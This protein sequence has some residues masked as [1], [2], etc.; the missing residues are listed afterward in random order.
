MA[1]NRIRPPS[2]YDNSPLGS[3]RGEGG[4]HHAEEGL[5][6]QY[7]KYGHRRLYDG[8]IEYLCQ[9]CLKVGV[10]PSMNVPKCVSEILK[11]P[12]LPSVAWKWLLDSYQSENP[13]LFKDIVFLQAAAFARGRITSMQEIERGRFA[14]ISKKNQAET[15]KRQIAM[16]RAKTRGTPEVFDASQWDRLRYDVLSKSEGRCALCGR[17]YREHGVT[18]EV[19]HIKPKSRFPELSLDIHNL[20]VLCKDCNRGKSNRDTRDWR[21]VYEPENLDIDLRGGIAL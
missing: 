12:V 19:D 9:R 8:L 15:F 14:I 3:Y 11:N 18:L 20:Q 10:K 21:P 6:S 16:E 13:E 7:S 5:H 4:W 17:S 2:E 1:K